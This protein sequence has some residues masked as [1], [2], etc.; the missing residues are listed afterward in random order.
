AAALG[1]IP[2]MEAGS[3]ASFDYGRLFTGPTLFA[4]SSETRARF[5]LYRQSKPW[6]H[7]PG[8]FMVAEAGGYAADLTGQPY[9][10]EKG[11][12]GL[13]LAADEGEWQRIHRAFAP[14]I[15]L[16]MQTAA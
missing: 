10:M 1:Q 15:D 12:D 2:A 16:L 13:L 11:K 4:R 5:L 14:A 7:V 8:L 9:D 6:D 3:A